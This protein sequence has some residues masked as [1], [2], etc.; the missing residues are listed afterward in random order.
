MLS[1]SVVSDS[2]QPYGLYIAHQAPLPTGILQAKILE[3]VAMSASRG[4]YT[5][6]QTYQTNK[7]KKVKLLSHIQLFAT[8]WT[9]AYQA[10]PSMGFSRQEYWSRLP[11][12]SPGD[13]PDP[14][15]EPG[16]PPLQADALPSELPEKPKHINFSIMKQR[17]EI[18]FLIWQWLY[19]QAGLGRKVGKLQQHIIWNHS[20]YGFEWDWIY[21][22]S[23]YVNN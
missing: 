2:L 17:Q 1:R 10:S 18:G 22:N 4:S 11:F 5:I 9:V 23:R 7:R 14:G 6:F 16:S 19:T 3:W 8:P 15:M 13:L 12:P 20:L 21:I